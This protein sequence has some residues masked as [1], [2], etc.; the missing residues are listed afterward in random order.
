MFPFL[1]FG[2][3]AFFFF[4]LLMNGA[5]E[6]SPMFLVAVGFMTVIGVYYT[7]SSLQAL[8]DEV[9]D[10]GDF[11]LVKKGKEEDRISLSNIINVDFSLNVKPLRITL[12]LATPGKFGSE[13]SF[14][15]P[16]Q[17]YLSPLPKS[18]I[19]DDLIV[20]ADKARRVLAAATS[21]HQPPSASAPMR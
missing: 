1:F 8:V 5:F 17:I 9:Y 6:K 7:K 12:T 18:H 11:L 16:P 14:A 13:I 3:L 15:P 2:F 20:R 19:A 10:C 4:L 21:P